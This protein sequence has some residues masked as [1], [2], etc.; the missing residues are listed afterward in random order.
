M[1]ITSLSDDNVENLYWRK[2]I[3]T[4]EIA[5]LALKIITENLDNLCYWLVL[6]LESVMCDKYVEIVTDWLK[7]KDWRIETK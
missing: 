1:N 5:A 6:G 3:E 4:K 7:R 2:W